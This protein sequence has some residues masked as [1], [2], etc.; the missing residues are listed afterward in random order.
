MSLARGEAWFT[1]CNGILSIPERKVVRC[2]AQ[3][4][5]SSV[6]LLSRCV[7]TILGTILWV[8]WKENRRALQSGRQPVQAVPQHT[9]STQSPSRF[10]IERLLMWFTWPPS[11][12]STFTWR[13]MRFEVCI[14][15]VCI[16]IYLFFQSEWR[17]KRYLLSWLLWCRS[18]INLQYL[19]EVF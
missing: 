5:D 1:A 7:S 4:K 3:L 18:F 6:S 17:L 14:P 15:L 16:G 19:Q 11:G 8:T 13:R 2:I 10:E 12:C 9:T